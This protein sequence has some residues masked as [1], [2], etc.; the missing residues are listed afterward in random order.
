MARN[1]PRIFRRLS[2][3]VPG[4]FRAFTLLHGNG[5]LAFVVFNVHL[6]MEQTTASQY[7]LHCLH[8]RR[9]ISR[10]SEIAMYDWK[11]ATRSEYWAILFL[12]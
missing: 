1:V 7:S 8:H 4:I 9:Y 11:L 3:A 10:W 6:H 2:S 5:A 12:P